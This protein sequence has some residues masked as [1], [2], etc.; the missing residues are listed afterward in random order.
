MPGSPEHVRE[1]Y[2][3]AQQGHR[4]LRR[5]PAITTLHSMKSPLLATVL[6]VLPLAAAACADNLKAVTG[7]RR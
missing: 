4:P 6:L 7:S 1:V 2:E 5:Q 3:E